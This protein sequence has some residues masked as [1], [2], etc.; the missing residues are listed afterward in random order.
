V[1][2]VLSNGGGDQAI[3]NASTGA[4]TGDAVTVGETFTFTFTVDASDG[5]LQNRRT[6]SIKVDDDADP[7]WVTGLGAFTT[8]ADEGVAGSTYTVEATDFDGQPQPIEYDVVAGSMPAGF[9]WTDVPGG[10]SL[11]GAISG[12]P[13]DGSFSDDDATAFTIRATDSLNYT[14]LSKT[15]KVNCTTFEDGTGTSGT[16]RSQKDATGLTTD[17]NLIYGVGTGTSGY[18][19]TPVSLPTENTEVLKADL[20]EWRTAINACAE[21]QGITLNPVSPLTTLLDDPKPWDASGFFNTLVQNATTGTTNITDNKALVDGASVAVTAPLSS[22]RST[23]WSTTVQHIFTVTFTDQDHARA[24]FNAGGQIRLAGSRTGGSVTTQ[25]SDWTTLLSSAGTYIFDSADYFALTTSY[26]S[27]A[28]YVGSGA[29]AANDWD[30]SVL[31]NTIVDGTGRGGK[32]NVITFRSEFRD[33][34]TGSGGGPDTVD[35]TLTSSVGMRNVDGT[36]LTIS[37]PSFLTTTA[38]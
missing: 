25:N 13:T 30:I 22:V 21:H 9:D 18:G 29:Y 23:A 35:G 32:G 26:I 31:S 4:I 20:L 34:H 14:D 15:I 6:F 33:D 36:P 28:N 11:T 17:I 24:F 19:Q 7:V 12:T 37:A 27:K 38:L 5:K 3:L 1:V 10:P 2:I 8:S 16:G